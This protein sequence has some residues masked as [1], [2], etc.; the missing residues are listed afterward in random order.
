MAERRDAILGAAADLFAEYEYEALSL[1][2]IA[3]AAGIS[4]PSVYRYFSSKEEIFL[5][6]LTE[7]RDSFL[8][9]FTKRILRLAAPVRARDIASVWTATA[10][11]HVTLLDLLPL[12]ITSLERN[13]SVDEVVKFKASG[14]L[15][16]GDV[17]KSLHSA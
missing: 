8:A 12:L 15:Q 9:E 14:N 4:K 10:L 3:E 16:M 11:R 6:I 1:N 7:Q 5:V 13:S 2:G 17:I